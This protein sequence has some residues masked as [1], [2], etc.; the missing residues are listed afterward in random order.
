MGGNCFLAF[1]LRVEGGGGRIRDEGI[2]I[3][4]TKHVD[5]SFPKHIP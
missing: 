1:S 2:I 5:H 4:N 3:Y